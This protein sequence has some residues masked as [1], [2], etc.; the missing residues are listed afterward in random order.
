MSNQTK[1]TD[2]TGRLAESTI[3][4]KDLHDVERVKE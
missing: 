1:Y 4:I 2:P 3:R